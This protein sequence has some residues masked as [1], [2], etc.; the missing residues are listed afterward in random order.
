[1]AFLFWD[2]SALAKRYTAETGSD[3]VDAVFDHL[4]AHEM[5]TTAWGYLETYSIL[6]RRKNGGILDAPTFRIAVTALQS[7]VIDDTG[8]SLLAVPDRTVLGGLSVM[9]R[10]NLNSTDAVLLSTLLR[11][12]AGGPTRRDGVIVLASDRRLARAVRTEGLDV[13]NPEETPPEAVPVIL[14]KAS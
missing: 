14:A 11:F 5:T 4:S 12:L 6:L 2:A 7:E 9:Q 1:M 3:T 8:F 13:L 10:H